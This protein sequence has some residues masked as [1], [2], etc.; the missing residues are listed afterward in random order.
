MRIWVIFFI[1]LFVPIAYAQ[2][3]YQ[4]YESVTLDTR[5]TSQINLDSGVDYLSSELYFF[6]RETEFQKITEKTYSDKVLV[7]QDYITYEWTNPEE[8]LAFYLD[9]KIK[10]NFNLVE[11][12]NKILYPI[13]V[14]EEYKEYLKS[15]DL[16]NSNN[17]LIKKQ[18]DDILDDEDDLYEVVYKLA[19]WTKDNI[20]YSLETLTEE[21]TQNSLW[22]LE[23]KR[24]VCDEL[25]VLFIAM[26][27]SRGIPAKFV[28]GQSYTNVIPGFGN[29]AWA[30]VYFPGKGWVPFDVTYGQY[31]YVDA[32]HI[33]MK[34]SADAKEPSVKYKWSPAGKELDVNP[35]NI[36]TSITSVSDKMPNYVKIN[37]N[38]LRNQVKSGSYVPIEIELENTKDFYIS[39]TLYITKAPSEMANNVRHVLLK[40]NEKKKIY[41]VINTP[42]NLDDRYLYT[43][44]IEILDFFGAF[45]EIEI[46]YA[47][48]YSYYSL[49]ES[50]ERV[51]QLEIENRNPESKIDVFCSTDKLKYYDYE[52]ATLICMVTNSDQKYNSLKLC[53]IDKC[54]S[55]DS[56]L[57]ETN[58]FI[59]NLPLEIGKKEHH[60]KL[61]NS[62]PI[63]SSYFDVNVVETPNLVIDNLNYLSEINYKG[64]S[65]IKFDITAKSSAKNIVI[66]M[67]EKELFKFDV[68]E[69]KENF[70][71]PFKGKYFYK[72]NHK[73][74]IEY[75]DD[76]GIKYRTEQELI[77]NVKNVP[78][79]IKIGNWWFAI[80]G[81]MLV[82]FFFRRK[83]FK[84][85]EPPK[86]IKKYKL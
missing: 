3:E 53:F 51:H 81:F 6:P 56:K 11:I 38:L 29:H 68:Y 74:I 62:V 28:S 5:I 73:I 76:N 9:Y 8:Q 41:W 33:K 79:Y 43:S 80:L 21:V 50:L 25:T 7:K 10:S 75:E 2:E 59:F 63:K 65:E 32:T 31:G 44:K 17:I 57:G 67:D 52:N 34:E 69:G 72:N 36:S 12:K 18:A 85:K 40:P 19:S 1:L 16:I 45:Q 78:F 55:F 66:N 47:N 86:L 15:T 27:R 54:M 4:N 46:E 64:S 84:L 26:L 82:L 39:T 20:N 48:K 83:L 30:E 77:I 13:E 58:D 22:V 42:D 23:N 71:V 14:P 60:A 24:G 61:S 35:L 49:E 37:F 70:V